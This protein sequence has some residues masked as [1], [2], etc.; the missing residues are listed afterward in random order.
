[1]KDLWLVKSAILFASCFVLCGELPAQ[2]P[3]CDEIV[4]MAGMARAGSSADLTNWKRKAGDSYRA[5][6]VFASRNFELH[7]ADQ[8]AASAILELIPSNQESDSVW[9]ELGESFCQAESVKDMTALGRLG[10]RLPRDLARAVLLV[11]GKMQD[12]VSY[13]QTSIGDPHSDYT[14]Q[15][16]K[17]CKARHKQFVDAVNNLSAKDKNWFVSKIFNL[18]GCH[19]L[20]F[21]EQ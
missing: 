10:D 1:M 15:M 8:S 6:V 2:E 13:A 20:L 4:A 17:V 19:P 9:H 16:Q 11:P 12:Y 14:V 5:Q 18:D 21:P 7:P 3:K